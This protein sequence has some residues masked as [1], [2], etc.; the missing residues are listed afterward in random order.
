M[1]SGTATI[2]G[3]GSGDDE[4]I[5]IGP[6]TGALI[7]KAGEMRLDSGPVEK[8]KKGDLFSVAVPAKVRLSDRLYIW[9]EN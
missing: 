3:S 9:T 8:V 7:F 1:D 6:T 2:S 5:V 4:I